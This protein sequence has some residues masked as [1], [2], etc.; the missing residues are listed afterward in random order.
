[1]KKNPE[2]NL[3]PKI[4]R[5][6]SASTEAPLI[7]D[8]PDGQKLVVGEIPNGTVIEVATWRGTGRPDSR[9]NRMMLGVSNAETTISTE[10]SSEIASLEALENV[11]QNKLTMIVKRISIFFLWLV[12]KSPKKNEERPQGNKSLPQKVQKSSTAATARFKIQFKK[13]S[14]SSRGLNIKDKNV[15]K[16]SDQNQISAETSEWLDSILNKSKP[17]STPKNTAN[18]ARLDIGRETS[19]SKEPRSASGRAPKKKSPQRKK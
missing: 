17:V 1:M 13:L 15:D 10:H 16:D 12:N 18:S 19:V 7:I 2:I 4:T 11:P 8:L 9:T 14:L 6:P 3:A 5:L